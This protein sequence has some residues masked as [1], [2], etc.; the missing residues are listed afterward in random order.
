[1]TLI[2]AMKYKNGTILAT[3]T[4]LMYGNI[5]RDQAVKLKILTDN[6][7]VASAGII[8]ATDDILK[9]VQDFCDSYNATFEDVFTH[10]SNTCLDWYDEN[11][12]K[13]GEDNCTYRFIIASPERIRRIIERGY[14]EESRDY[15]CEG[16]GMDYGEYILQNHYKEN[17]IE[18]DA[19]ELAIYTILETSK[20][21]PSVGEDIQMAIFPNNENYKFISN[22]EI[23]EI[24]TSLAPISRDAIISQIK[25]IENIV[26]LRTSVNE[27]WEKKFRF[28]LLLQNEKAIHQISLPCRNES[29]FNNNILA[30]ALLVEQLNVKKMKK[31]VNEKEGSINIL[32]NILKE[33]FTEYPSKI[34]YNFRDIMTLRSKKFPIHSQDSRFTSVV[35]NVIGYYPP[36]WAELYQKALDML[37]ESYELLVNLTNQS[38][39]DITPEHQT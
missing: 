18:K 28:K 37:I 13:I 33:K 4:R 14:S 25:N 23:E 24:K 6:I 36:E 7:G 10:I 9:S 12:D 8:G 5:K 26:N 19:I 1:M 3:D 27:N 20:I 2:I 16:S 35:I 22:D 21:N 38:D 15:V 34:I 31:T 11:I 30:L 39:S 29:E 17:M 32:E